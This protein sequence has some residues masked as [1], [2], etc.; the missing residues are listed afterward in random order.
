MNN[1]EIIS[2]VSS[3]LMDGFD[4]IPLP[5]VLIVQAKGCGGKSVFKEPAIS[6]Y[7][8]QSEINLFCHKIAKGQMMGKDK[9][10]AGKTK[11]FFQICL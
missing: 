11:F 1:G 9:N 8:N 5:D 7:Q 4:V 3:H 2:E 10:G 6:K